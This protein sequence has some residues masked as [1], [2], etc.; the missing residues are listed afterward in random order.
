M[1]KADVFSVREP[2]RMILQPSAGGLRFPGPGV[3]IVSQSS[4]ESFGHAFGVTKRQRGQIPKVCGLAA[5]WSGYERFTRPRRHSSYRHVR[6]GRYV[7]QKWASGIGKTP[8][9][10]GVDWTDRKA[11]LSIFASKERPPAR[12]VR[13]PSRPDGAPAT[14]RGRHQTRFSRTAVIRHGCG[15][16]TTHRASTAA[17]RR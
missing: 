10:S 7:R 5:D 9:D 2:D 1:G 16:R 14:A 6:Y 12:A 8:M 13:A 15:L 3:L 4:Q 11:G 17:G